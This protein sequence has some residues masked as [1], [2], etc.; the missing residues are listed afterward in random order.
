MIST[1][2]QFDLTI[3]QDLE[4]LAIPSL[5]LLLLDLLLSCP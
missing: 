2:T 3:S 5:D 4:V 1:D